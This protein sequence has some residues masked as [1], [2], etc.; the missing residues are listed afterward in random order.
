MI[1]KVVSGLKNR[2]L[3]QL[4]SSVV[5]TLPFNF[6]NFRDIVTQFELRFPSP[7]P[8]VHAI[9]ALKCYRCQGPHLAKE[10]SLVS[11]FKCAGQHKTTQCKVPQN[12]LQCTKCSMSN[13]TT[14]RHREFPGKSAPRA[15]NGEEV[16]VFTCY[17]AST[18]FVDGAVSINNGGKNFFVNSKLLVDTGALLPSGIAI[19][20]EFYVHGMGGGMSGG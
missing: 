1:Q 3:A 10:C 4:T 16:G 2:D 19:S 7:P 11:C 14:A 20:E 15:G 13:Y 17:N 12:K 6:N 8:A 9:S 5:I 18:S